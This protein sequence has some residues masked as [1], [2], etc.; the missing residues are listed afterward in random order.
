MGRKKKKKSE[1]NIA[2]SSSS[3]IQGFDDEFVDGDLVDDWM[4]TPEVQ[5][6]SFIPIDR[7]K[8]DKA[9]LAFQK[10]GDL[11]GMEEVYLNRVQTLEIWASR[12]HYLA[13]GSEDMYSELIQVFM[14]AV[15][16]YKKKR[17]CEVN[18]KTVW[19]KTPFNTYLWYSIANYVR[20]L[21]SGKR[22]KK[23]RAIGYDGPLSSMILSLDFQ[24]KDREGSETSLKDVISEDLSMAIHH[25]DEPIHLKEMLKVMSDD[26]PVVYKFLTK[27]CDGYSLAAAVKDCKTVSG[28]VRLNKAQVKKF[29]TSRR[30]NRMVSNLISDRH[31][32]K[33]S[34]KLIGYSVN[35][36]YLHYSIEMKKT[37]EAD[38]VMKTVRQ[39]KKNKEYYMKKLATISA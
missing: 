6:S 13:G 38:A 5:E 4:S 18:G 1:D 20:N 37:A 9:V 12:Y 27:L 30:Y 29:G 28:R 26:D 24:Y 11:K 16:G 8:E 34:F 17:K 22:A 3:K 31:N 32:I 19:K 33:D 2:D 39:L 35:K 23:R 10:T 21:K 25:N 7:E 36:S 14:K 15:N